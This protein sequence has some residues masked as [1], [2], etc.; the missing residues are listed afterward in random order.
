MSSPE[1]SGYYRALERIT[2]CYQQADAS[3]DLSN[4]GLGHVPPEIGQLIGLSRLHLENN[5]LIALPKEISHLTALVFLN[6]S[7]NQITA[8]PPQIVRLPALT[9]LVLDG[10]HL[11]KL[12]PEIGQLGQLTEL[13]VDD[14]SLLDLP[15]EIGRLRG[16]R[17][18][19]LRSNQICSLPSSMKALA[20]LER[21][22][23]HGNPG[24]HLEPSVLGPMPGDNPGGELASARA[25]LDFYFSRRTQ[26]TRPLNEV[27]MILVG[28]GGAGKTSTV[29]ALRGRPFQKS[30]ESTPGIALC[31]WQMTDCSGEPVLAHVWDFAGQ[32]ITHALHRFFFSVRSIYVVVLAGRDDHEREDAEYWLRLIKAF[33]SDAAGEGPPVIV[34]L[35]KWDKAGHRPKVDRG[36]LR[37][38]YPFIRGFVETDCATRRGIDE[39]NKLLCAEVEKLPWVREPFPGTWDAVRRALAEGG[40]ARPHLP[41][42]EYRGLCKEHG[43]A[44]ERMQDSLSEILHK[45]GA[46]LNYRNDPRLREA[47]VLQPEWLTNHVYALMRHAETQ[48]GVFRQ[49]DLPAVLSDEPDPAMHAYLVQLMERFEIAYAPKTGAGSFDCAQ[50]LRLVPQAL[51]DEQPEAAAAFGREPE[52]TRL[53]YSYAALPEG[54]VARAIVRLH[55][56]IEEVDGKKQ[57]WAS[58]AILTREGARALLRKEPQDRVVMITVTGADKKARQQLAGLSQAV[59]RDI[60]GEVPGLDPTEETQVQG[61]W[62]PT[63]VLE[64]DE[65]AGR[66]TGIYINQATVLANPKEANDQYSEQ[67]ARTD[68]VWKPSVF[69]SYS[70]S[71][72]SQRKR[73]ELELK[74]LM[75]A[76]LLA[77][78]W[79]DRMID[80][81]DEWDPAIQHAL[82][83]DVVIVLLTTQALTTNYIAEHEI[84]KAMARHDA[85]QTVVVPLILEECRW[86]LTALKKLTALPEKAKPLN[87]WTRPADAWKT[88]SE[89]LE[90]VCRRLMKQADAA[91]VRPA[92]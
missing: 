16:L 41:Y 45:L 20:K 25:I 48:E 58:G 70:K 35:N 92:M 19:W 10:N 12:P 76:G 59:L 34:T 87:K 52:A 62:V 32:V 83:A 78:H 63:S 53:R 49:A 72:V 18:L 13:S 51:P 4:L 2:A 61:A 27:K 31:D 11:A 65:R 90:R 8:L 68:E 30:E 73:L 22:Y 66:P 86:D 39:L 55:E 24:L 9:R 17:T 26:T 21:L 64:G 77:G 37:E 80:P 82:E 1:K 42:A 15:V 56:L 43:V 3:L 75:N 79:H 91:G 6:L 33:G 28:R 88:V 23:L 38:R 47:T 67:P 57:Q 40:K 46:A 5:R 54:L 74:I 14:N 29:T 89:G 69:I 85:G 60:H 81:G 44:E 36:A 50:D 7:N 84:P 71:N